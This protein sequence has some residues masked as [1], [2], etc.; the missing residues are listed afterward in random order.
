[1]FCLTS[2]SIHTVDSWTL[3]SQ[4]TALWLMAEQSSSNRYFLQKAHDHILGSALQHSP[5]GAGGMYTVKSPT[6]STGCEKCRTKKMAKK[7]LVT[8]RELEQEGRTL[9]C[10]TSARNV[11]SGSTNFSLHCACL[12]ITM[13]ALWVL[14]WELQINFSE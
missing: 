4:P 3:N 2:Y 10:L 5:C 1:M 8:V 13:K 6:K 14:I 9:P 11:C 7:T 12:Q